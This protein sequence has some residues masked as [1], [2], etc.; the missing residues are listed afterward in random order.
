MLKIHQF[1]CLND[2]YG[3]LAHDP[4]S[5]DTAAID[6]PDA[7]KY[8][9]E[10]EALG[11]TISA[12]WNTHWHPD[13]AGGN[14]KI[15]DA[16]GCAIIGPAGEAEKIPGIEQPVKGG[17]TVRLGD[18]TAHVI[19]VPGHTL[20]HI[21]FHMPAENTAF[22]GDAVFALGCGRVFEGDMAMM[23]NSMQAIKALP[24]E[25]TLYCAH[26]YTQANARFA[27]T[28]E[29]DNTALA[30]YIAEID[31]KRAKGER[32]VPMGLAR[33]LETN[34]FL[35][36]DVASLQAAMGHPGDAVAT[37]GEIRGRK[38]RF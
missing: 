15:K 8:L 31:A 24:P 4:V 29:T 19:D 23:W 9:A 22:V 26:E 34:P 38:D 17:D 14:L 21:A 28:I 20:G 13:H 30:D 7:D 6:T 11:W 25:T 10:A 16:T 27:E 2:N 18:M 12:I 37:F 1:P 36:A 5:G 32:T 3:Y 33:E 35:R